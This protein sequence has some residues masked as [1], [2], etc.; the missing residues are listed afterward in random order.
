MYQRGSINAASLES[1][2][3]TLRIEL[4]KLA[5]Q[6]SQP[7]DYIALKTLYAPPGRVLEGMIV[8]ADGASWNPGGGAG[9]Y[10][11]DGGAWIKL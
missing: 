5:L 10:A 8:K 4:D 7:S 9:V 2:A 11:F 3:E 1:L 6:A